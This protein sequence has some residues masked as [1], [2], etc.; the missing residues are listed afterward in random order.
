MKKLI[1]TI[2]QM[3]N[4]Y[5]PKCDPQP[6]KWNSCEPCKNC[7]KRANY[8]NQDQ[9]TPCCGTLNPPLF[10]GNLSQNSGCF[11]KIIIAGNSCDVNLGISVYSISNVTSFDME[12]YINGSGV[13]SIGNGGST[14]I[15]VLNTQDISFCFGNFDPKETGIFEVY[16]ENITCG[17][18][19]Q[20]VG[21]FE[22]IV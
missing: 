13:D 16:I 1:R 8:G 14:F 21:T 9:P 2:T 12:I 7:G 19:N 4:K 20:L 15:T 3:G 5:K 11:P 22:V 6:N 10:W 17:T 18:G